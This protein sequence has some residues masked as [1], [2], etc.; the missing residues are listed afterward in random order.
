[1]FHFSFDF[2][3][4]YHLLGVENFTNF[5]DI[6][7]K[8]PFPYVWWELYVARTDIIIGLNTSLKLIRERHCNS[9]FYISI[10][11]FTFEFK[12]IITSY[13]EVR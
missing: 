1:M 12:F 6:R 5:I 2:S 11:L 7:R 9:I 4:P 3:L 8:L 10:A 13:K